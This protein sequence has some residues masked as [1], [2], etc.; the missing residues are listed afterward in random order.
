MLLCFI[1]PLKFISKNFT[2]LPNDIINLIDT[3][4]IT[5]YNEYI[6]QYILNVNKNLYDNKNSFKYTDNL[7]NFIIIQRDYNFH[8]LSYVLNTFRYMI[9]KEIDIIIKNNTFCSLIKTNKYSHDNLQVAIH[10]SIGNNKINIQNILYL[11]NIYDDIN[12]SLDIHK[13]SISFK[14]DDIFINTIFKMKIS[15]LFFKILY[16]NINKKITE[17]IVY[18]DYITI[19]NPVKKNINKINK[20]DKKLK[21]N[22]IISFLI[23][24]FEIFFNKLNKKFD[25]ILDTNNK[26]SFIINNNSIILNTF[27][28]IPRDNQWITP[29]DYCLSC[30]SINEYIKNIYINNLFSIF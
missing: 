7:I 11:N 13:D 4:L 5:T 21:K 18:N 15:R 29:R 10:N 9:K 3:F 12:Q 17:W 27:L 16:K 14:F 28:K 26:N 6:I 8:Y 2:I 22:E 23:T 24:Y 20:N 25:M 30:H 1:S 19:T